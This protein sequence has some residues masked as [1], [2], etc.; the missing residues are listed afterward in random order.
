MELFETTP[1][2]AKEILEKGNR[3]IK[4][5]NNNKFYKVVSININNETSIIS[6]KK[7]HSLTINN[8]D[9]KFYIQVPRNAKT[10]Y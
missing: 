1:N 3:I 2:Q 5:Q 7:G 10:I 8:E 6:V 9:Y 4:V